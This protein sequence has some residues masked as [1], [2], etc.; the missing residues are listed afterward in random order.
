MT[1][2]LTTTAAMVVALC[3]HVAADWPEFRGPTGQGIS[4]ATGLP[5]SWDRRTNIGWKT[6]I[7]GRGWSSPVLRDGAIY[8][9]TAVSDV[10]GD[11]RA[12]DGSQSL[13]VLRVDASTGKVTWN[14]EVF[15]HGQTRIQRKNSHASPTPI[16]DGKRVWVHFGANGTAC[17]DVDGKVIWRNES[18]DYDPVHGSGGSPALVGSLLIFSCDGARDPFVVA[19]DART[20][21]ERWRTPRPPSSERKQF[22]FST[23]LAIQVDGATQVVLP[24]ANHAA[25]YVPENGKE[26]WR[27]RYPGGYSVVPRPVFDA[28]SGL[29]FVST[30]YDTPR[31]LA[32]R[33]DG[34]GDVTDTHVAWT[35][36]S[37]VS[38]NPSFLLAGRELYVVSD[39]GVVSCLDAATGR[40]HWRQRLSGS[41]SASPVLAD[42]RIYLLA[43]DGEGIVLAAGK[44]YRL[45]SRNPLDERALASYAVGDGAL[46]ARTLEHLWRIEKPEPEREAR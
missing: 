20:G 13:R 39:G 21:K 9:T 15:R 11:P 35:L 40:R 5:V 3:G 45:L 33:P 12:L 31:L 29:V 23:P 34:R 7:P 6:P 4:T 16:T 22:A 38:H 37:A 1:R 44:R 8:L 24:G 18:I 30:S 36:R 43:E 46:F 2:R 28:D 42:G 19:L 32:I 27:V 17:L 10:P 26:I 25:S 14:V 41:F